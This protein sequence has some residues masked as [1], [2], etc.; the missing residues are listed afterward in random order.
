MY[1]MKSYFVCLVLFVLAILSSFQGCHRSHRDAVIEQWQSDNKSFRV[2]VTAYKETG[3]NVNG[4]YYRFEATR[5]GS[6]DWREIM[7]FRHDDDPKIPTD[8]V[9][10]VDNETGYVFM[11]WMYAVTTD[12]GRTW[13][14]WSA[15][16][17]LAGWQC[18]NYKLISNVTI[19][20]DGRGVMRINP[21]QGRRGEVSELRTNDYGRNWTQP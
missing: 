3:A 10:Y 4:A 1:F 21:I 11:G 15:E 13:S 9:R 17:D 8:Q 18:C 20:S 19:E 16:K 7:T 2:R 12:A 5:A 6:D 14:V